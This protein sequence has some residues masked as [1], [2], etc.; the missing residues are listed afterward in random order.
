M[1]TAIWDAT[2][3]YIVGN[4]QE[5]SILTIEVWG[6]I[7]NEDKERSG[8]GVYYFY[9]FILKFVQ[10]RDNAFQDQNLGIIG[11][12]ENVLIPALLENL[13]D[14]SKYNDNDDGDLNVANST[15]NCLMSIAEAIKDKFLD[16]AIKFVGSIY[17]FK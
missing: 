12:V 5:L 8:S 11:Q 17:L 3:K 13:L 4:D 6:T 2:S 1:Y 7:A 15:K 14:S 9:R 10:G 16:F